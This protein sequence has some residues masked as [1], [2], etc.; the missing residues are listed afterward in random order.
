M[1]WVFSV[2][3]LVFLEEKRG[4]DSVHECSGKEA[5]FLARKKASG[6]GTTEKREVR[7]RIGKLSRKVSFS[8]KVAI[9][10]P[11]WRGVTYA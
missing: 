3:G 7:T 6:F 5:F 2:D 9:P 4:L 8:A 10:G 11:E 1:S